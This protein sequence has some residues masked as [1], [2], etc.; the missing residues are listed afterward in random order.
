M[1]KVF[2][3]LALSLFLGGC[4]SPDRG[5]WGVD[6]RHVQID[7]RRYEVFARLDE[8]RPRV[9]VIRMGY[10]RRSE[11]VAILPAMLQAATQAT[12]CT[13][14]EGSAVGDSGVMT[15]RLRCG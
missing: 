9:Q 11:H 3:F 6:A 14:I 8:T 15:A 7:G 1:K 13:V 4:A 10:A 2:W 5:Y 12:G